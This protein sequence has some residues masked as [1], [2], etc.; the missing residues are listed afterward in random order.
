MTTDLQVPEGGTEQN[1]TEYSAHEQEA[2]AQG[3]VPKEEFNGDEHKW[4]DAAEFLR[5]GELFKK[6]ESQSSELKQV[7]RAL[8]ELKKHHANVRE[9]EYKR[10]LDSLK[11]Q[12][13]EALLEGD[14]DALIDVDERIELV[15]E[16]QKAL[17]EEIAYEQ[18][19]DTSSNSG[20]MHPEFVSWTNRNTW[21]KTNAPMRAFADELG[22]ELRSQGKSPSDILAEVEKQVRKEFPQRFNNP[23]RTAASTVEGSTNRGSTGSAKFELS[24]DERRVMKTFV[25][26]GV[27][28]EQDYIAE[29]RKVRGA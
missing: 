24:D 28:S 17:Q 11:Q 21:Y 23:K 14:A 7:R 12:K 26:Q 20:E 5:R 10:A 4:V 8:E 19:E 27:M 22:R 16:Q 9:V 1:N 18:E 29:L 2:L 25:R 6:I 15:K 13:K 3:W